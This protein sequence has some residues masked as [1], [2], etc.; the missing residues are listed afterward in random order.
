MSFEKVA[1]LTLKG[2]ISECSA[3]EQKAIADTAENIRQLREGNDE[4]WGVA[5]SL[6]SI[7]FSMED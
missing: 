4:A 5:I 7:E 2:A 6:V 1:L 3:E